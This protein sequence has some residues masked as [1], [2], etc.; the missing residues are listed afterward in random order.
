MLMKHQNGVM[1]MKINVTQ[2]W[3]SKLILACGLL[4]GAYTVRDVPVP[5]P[6]RCPSLYQPLKPSSDRRDRPL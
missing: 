5:T 2:P 3:R 1:R 6:Q 4:P